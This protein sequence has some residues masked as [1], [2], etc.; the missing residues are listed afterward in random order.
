MNFS[1][2]DIGTWFD[3]GSSTC[4]LPILM[5]PLQHITFG[6]YHMPDNVLQQFYMGSP[7][8][9]FWFDFPITGNG[10]LFILG[11]HPCNI[12]ILVKLFCIVPH[13]Q[14]CLSI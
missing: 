11:L 8:V 7:L 14:K 5:K 1:I 2:G 3:L 9:Y 13:T 4:K 10:V 12:N 6:C